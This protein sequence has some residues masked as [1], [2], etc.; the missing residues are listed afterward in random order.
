MNGNIIANPGFVSV[1]GTTTDEEGN[2]ALESSILSGWSAMMSIGQ[3]IGMTSLPFFSDRYGR[4]IAMYTYWF[5]LAMSIVAESV[6]RSWPT[7]LVAKLLA[8]I[9]VG[10]LQTTIPTYI[11][12]TAPIRIRGGLLMTYNFWFG[13]GNFFAPVALQV[14]SGYAPNNWLT[15]ILTQW[16][17]IGLMLII[18]LVIPESP[19][20]AASRGKAEKAKKSLQWLHR[21]VPGYD[22]EH[23]YRL[24]AM[25]VE[26]E[27]ELAAAS[28]NEHW[29]AIFKGVDGKRTIT[30]LW[31]LMTQQF[32]GLK[33]FS[34][35]AS[36]F[37]QQAG[38][39]DP[40]LAT[41][42][43]TAIS[44]VT[45]ILIITVADKLGRRI[46][47]CSGS[48]LSWFAC[49][50]VGIL[51]VAPRGRA[52]NYLFIFFACLWSTPFSLI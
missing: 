27:K 28:R 45:G 12:E 40:F 7:W 33:L 19:A 9:G 24:L 21:E 44:I 52:T 10:C 37:F 17:Q 46:I 20:W 13:L 48:T 4:K 26:H 11:A 2:P 25:A 30:A 1:F 8:G 15:P 43:T 22:V 18:Y 36:F 23:Q 34:T 14:M 5:I 32:I 29:Y 35:F 41:S 49:A 50:A 51:G 31:T 3:I 47:S 16:A 6:G 39:E 42:I 38:V